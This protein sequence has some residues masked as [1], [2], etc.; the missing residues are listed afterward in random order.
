MVSPPPLWNEKYR[1]SNQPGRSRGSQCLAPASDLQGTHHEDS[2][3]TGCVI[4]HPVQTDARG[5]ASSTNVPDRE[6][7]WQELVT[8]FA[9]DMVPLF[10]HHPSRESGPSS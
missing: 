4:E 9:G 8:D 1:S 2:S 7:K 3:N 5:I 10:G 6:P